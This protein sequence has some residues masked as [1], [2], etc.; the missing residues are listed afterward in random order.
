MHPL[1]TNTL[2]I[3]SS[4]TEFL[5][6]PICNGKVNI[7]DETLICLESEC[8]SE[9][10]IISGIPILINEADSIFKFDDYKMVAD[11]LSLTDRLRIISSYLPSLSNNLSYKSNFK[12]LNE[13]L[14]GKARPK[15]LIIG[16]A[17]IT[18]GTELIIRPQNIV[19]ESDV[20]FGPRTQIIIDSHSIPFQEGTFDAV[21]VQ[22]VLEYV[23]DPFKCVAEIHRVLKKSGVVYASS[24][25]I[26]Q[27]KAGLVDYYRFTKLGHRRLFNRFVEIESG[28]FAGPGVALGW[29]IR[30][31]LCSFTNNRYLKYLLGF[32]VSL[33]FFWLKWLDYIIE[34]LGNA[35]EGASGFYFVGMKSDVKLS[36]LDLINV[37]KS[38]T[39]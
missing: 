36:D 26:Q 35:N 25:F 3:E 16:G 24:P 22:T 2:K 11:T 13:L 34:Y 39:P 38:K 14:K 15:I 12:L 19:V 8:N 7:L 1:K 6:C 37:F 31:F 4:I 33:L 5:V 20:Y 32:F 27:T 29:S 30:T 23:G 18:A 28:V 17:I 21:I 10:P 9:Y